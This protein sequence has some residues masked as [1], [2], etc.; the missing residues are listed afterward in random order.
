MQGTYYYLQPH[1]Q[2]YSMSNIL[3]EKKLIINEHLKKISKRAT[4]FQQWTTQ[5][6]KQLPCY[7]LLSLFHA[8]TYADP[9]KEVI[10]SCHREKA[11]NPQIKFTELYLAYDYDNE[12][13]T[14]C[15]DDPHREIM[16]VETNNRA[17]YQ[18]HCG[19]ENYFLAGHRKFWLAQSVNHSYSPE[20]KPYGVGTISNWYLISFNEN[21]YICMTSSL[22][23][24]G[25][26]AA[27]GQYY[28]IENA[29]SDN[30]ELKA[31]FYFFDKKFIDKVRA[32]GWTNG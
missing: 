19:S 20:I 10:T 8:N 3:P 2:G 30:L 13:I 18:E 21:H 12:K 27:T 26:A 16:G 31:H 7:L 14:S 6:L 9:P 24:N 17:F 29:F 32:R 4:Q 5:V 1:Q 25:W 11:I 28:L 22:G 15:P 23:P